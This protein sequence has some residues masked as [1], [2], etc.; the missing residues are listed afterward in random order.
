MAA[1]TQPYQEPGAD[2]V[3]EHDLPALAA[4]VRAEVALRGVGFRS[5]DGQVEFHIDPVPRVI[6]AQEWAG[7]ERGLG[8]RVRALNAFVAD[9]YGER[10][11]FADGAVPGRLLEAANHE[12]AMRGVTPP[13]GVWIGIAGL[14]LVRD[15][16]G[17]FLVLE[18]NAMTPS[19]MA[20]AAAARGAVAA[21]VDGSPVPLDGLPEL[22][23]G[24]LENAR[25]GGTGAGLAVLLT[26]GPR[27]SAHWEHAWLARTLG[28]P[29][30]TPSSLTCAGDGLT[31]HGE[32]I[33]VIYRRTDADRLDTRVGEL[34]A[35]AVRS[36]TV[37]VINGFGTGVAD[38]KLAH[39]YVETMVEYY[40]GE[41]PLLP[42][43]P[44]LDLGVPEVLEQALDTLDELVIKPRDGHG[45][46]GVVICAQAGPHE[47]D[48]LRRSLRA[49][50]GDHI[51]QPLV[52]LSTHATVV[53]GR[54]EERHVDL[55]PFV[56]LHSPTDARVLPG[57]LTR[58]ALEAGAMVVN[59]TRN[60]G[61]KDTWVLEGSGGAP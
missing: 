54:L 52:A 35:P 30:V 59:S 21:H 37:G 43:V 49:A 4:A 28:I 27:N 2:E 20:Y 36:G 40:L 60:G 3:A 29:L 48:A 23:A 9:V 61:A 6:A 8:Q 24:T 39:A 32:P 53:D 11:I 13:G 58:V 5:A 41:R 50:P 25:P 15:P 22:L 16:E 56:F 57:G 33:A 10:R 7:L 55:R 38:D 47:L 31:L 12:P 34:L 46:H 42:S 18:D 17:R 26:D 1:D 45:G 51:A 19:G 14:D 44:T